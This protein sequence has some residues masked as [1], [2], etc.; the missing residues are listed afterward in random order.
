MG[1]AGAV[2]AVVVGCFG[3]RPLPRSSFPSIRKFNDKNNKWKIF[4]KCFGIEKYF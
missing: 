2:A 1:E 4:E 3:R